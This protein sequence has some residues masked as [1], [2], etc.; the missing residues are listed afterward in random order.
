VLAILIES[1]AVPIGVNENWVVYKQSGLQPLPATLTL[2]PTAAETYRFVAALPAQSA[3]VE[4][5]LGEPA[6]DIRY[7]LYSTRHWRPLV[8]GYSGGEP[9][10]YAYLNQSLQDLWTRPER[11]WNALAASRATHAI[12]HEHFYTGDRGPRVSAWL[13]SN[14]ATEVGAFGSNRVFALRATPNP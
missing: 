1:F 11:A 2:E 10:D 7:M 8:N 3:I 6:F 12:L 13:R 4:L 14:G 5:P 9:D